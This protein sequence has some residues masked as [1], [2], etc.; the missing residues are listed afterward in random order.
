ML[1]TKKSAEW[2]KHETTRSAM[3]EVWTSIKDEEALKKVCDSSR[4]EASTSLTTRNVGN[5]YRAQRARKQ[6]NYLSGSD[7]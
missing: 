1:E 3:L 4:I 5:R 2:A 6:P 7:H